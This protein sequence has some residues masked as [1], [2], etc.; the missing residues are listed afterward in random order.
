MELYL[1]LVVDDAEFLYDVV[2][3]SECI[4]LFIEISLFVGFIDNEVPDEKGD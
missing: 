4:C 1:L 3:P 2:S